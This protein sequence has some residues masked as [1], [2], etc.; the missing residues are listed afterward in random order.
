MD[1]GQGRLPSV[2]GLPCLNICMDKHPEKVTVKQLHKFNTYIHG[3]QKENNRCV[4]IGLWSM[5][6]TVHLVIHSLGEVSCE[7]RVLR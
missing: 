7:L 1:S 2:A 4:L 6:S 3:K 5:I